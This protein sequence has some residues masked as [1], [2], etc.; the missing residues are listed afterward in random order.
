M[1]QG[2]I[3]TKQQ[4]VTGRQ[5]PLMG[6]YHSA[7]LRPDFMPSRLL[8]KADHIP[9]FTLKA[10]DALSIAV[11]L[12]GWQEHLAAS[13]KWP[14]MHSMASLVLSCSCSSMM[15]QWRV[16]SLRRSLQTWAYFLFAGERNLYHFHRR[17]PNCL[18]LRSY[19]QVNV[20][21]R[22]EYEMIW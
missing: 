14:A 16:T 21:V 4:A 18:W 5:W 3:Q 2:D 8:K 9:H 22:W 10:E 6:T 17:K 1:P 19:L 15:V 7:L 12:S 20:W 13:T 11:C